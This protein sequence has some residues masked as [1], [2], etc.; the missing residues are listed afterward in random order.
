[1][2]DN[3]FDRP[4]HTAFMFD[5]AGAGGEG[6][7]GGDGS[8]GGDGAVVGG[9][10][11]DPAKVEPLTFEKVHE[12]AG[13][14]YKDAKWAQT[15]KGEEG[16]KNFFKSHSEGLKLIGKKKEELIPGEKATPEEWNHF[17]SLLGRPESAAGYELKAEAI[18]ELGIPTDQEFVDRF[19]GVAYE[20]GLT[21]KQV[22]GLLKWQAEEANLAASQ[23]TATFENTMSELRGVWGGATERH[24]TLANRAVV[25]L[26]GEDGLTFMRDSGA[27]NIPIL[28]KAFAKM[29]NMMAERGLIDPDVEGVPG[30][31]DAHAEANRI[32]FDANH[33][34]HK[35][36]HDPN[37]PNHKSAVEKSA[38]LFG[39]KFNQ[40]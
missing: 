12:A 36:Y 34:L 11:A 21:P 4:F 30:G 8:G 38:S 27:G 10:V 32:I 22:D 35:A 37:H 33:P 20:Y 18:R 3:L 19:A 40:A 14:E 29:G 2:K 16:L 26:M 28:I 15:Y 13:P 9:G 23:N 1:M 39:I 6:A 7:G 5:A 31:E 25:A 24:V 17:Y